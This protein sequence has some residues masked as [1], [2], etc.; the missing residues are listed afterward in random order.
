M[1]EPK[2]TPLHR[3][4]KEAGGKFVDFAGHELP[5]QFA[6]RGFIE[7]HLWCRS[8]AALFDV[9][10]MCQARVRGPR[11]ELDSVFPVAP[12]SVAAGRT[13]YTQLLNPGGGTVDD[14]LLANDGD[15]LFIVF[16]ASR[17]EAA[18]GA[19]SA[20]APGAEV[21]V[22]S[23]RAL[24]A[25]Q[26]PRAE[27]ALCPVI[28]G[29]EGLGFMESA[30][31]EFGG[32]PC[33]VSRSGYTGEDGFEVS[34][35]AE[36]AEALCERLSAHPD[37]GYAGLGA[38]DSLRLEAG[39]CLYGHEL[40]EST[41]PVE[42]GLAWSIPK[43]RRAQGGYV[44]SGRVAEQLEKGAGKKLAGLKVLGKVPVRQG[45]ALFR[46]EQGVGSVTSGVYSPTLRFPVALGYV[47][48]DCSEPGTRLHAEVR[49]RRVECE[50]ASLPFVKHNYKRKG[51]KDG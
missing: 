7:E 14:L 8:R 51:R 34:V 3:L 29:A 16:N 38:R 33:R 23:D 1:G 20:A 45:A 31:L 40:D 41:T 30:W 50:V 26:G 37:V 47:C 44:G 36:A 24:V 19:L 39:L 28:G 15:S 17:K 46:G 4:L 5:M 49:G 18:L 25:L 6:G 21:E 42:A 13:S 11:G 32:S 9:S 27:S 35:P 48:P 43:A 10:H 22:L 2:R 12:S